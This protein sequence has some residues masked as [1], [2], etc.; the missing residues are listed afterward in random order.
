MDMYYKLNIIDKTY[1]EWSVSYRINKAVMTN[2]LRKNTSLT[3]M[4]SDVNNNMINY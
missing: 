3:K 2:F 4:I 1:L